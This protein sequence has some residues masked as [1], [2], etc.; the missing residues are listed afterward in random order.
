MARINPCPFK[1]PFVPNS[2]FPA[3]EIPPD[4]CVYSYRNASAGKIR[5]AEWAG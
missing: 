3:E 2:S 5:E 4:K 1:T